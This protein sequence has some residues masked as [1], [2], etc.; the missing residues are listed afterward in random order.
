MTAD[1]P[2]AGQTMDHSSRISGWTILR[3]TI[4]ERLDPGLKAGLL[5][6]GDDV[7]VVSRRKFARKQQ[8]VAWQVVV[9][10]LR[11]SAQ[12]AQHADGLHDHLVRAAD[13]DVPPRPAGLD[14]EF[15]QRA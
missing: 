8:L 14:R 12:V 15:G 1:W 2:R 13:V 4:P 7:I 5:A 9:N 3:A 6:D 11:R 10:A